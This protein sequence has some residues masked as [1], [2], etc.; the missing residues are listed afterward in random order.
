M[1]VVPSEGTLLIVDDTPENVKVLFKFL[2]DAGFK[3]L[4]AQ[5]GEDGIRKAEHALPDLVLLDVMMP[6]MNGFEVCQVFKSR[7]KL[8]AIPVIF[9]TALT[10]TV[11]KVRGFDVGAADYITKPI[12]QEEVLARVTAHLRLYKLQ[13]QLQYKN[14]ELQERT[15]QL[16]SEIRHRKEVQMSL[17]TANLV[18]AQRTVELQKRTQE[19][20][21]RN[22]ELDAFAHTVAH[23][24]KNPLSGVIGLSEILLEKC[25]PDKPLDV[26]SLDRLQKINDAAMQILGII[27]AILLLAGVS[28]H[29]TVQ[30]DSVDMR[31][32]IQQVINTR[33]STL[34]NQYRA[35]IVLPE[36]LPVARGYTPWI[37]EVWV[38]YLTNGM[39]YG[40]EIP[41]LEVSAE[42]LADNGVKYCIRDNGS[43]ITVEQQNQLFTPFT[44]LHTQRADGH[45]LGL[46]IVK[47][48]VEKLG[49]CV[50][51]ESE[52]GQGSI[53]YFTLPI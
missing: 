13:R 51:V 39:K 49:G 31:S 23:D 21:Q 44:R 37:E 29:K 50:G 10:D 28:R 4:V 34:I 16:Q 19:L 42:I 6:K 30:L 26:K 33:L 3:V 52:L 5:D 46:S 38:N 45:G 48:I 17:E 15:E 35:T 40:G 7:D 8:K 2:T 14:N 27:N 36:T 24:L 53:F 25:T 41:H 22:M 43:G 20:E 12:Q 32:L 18:L 11:D 47:Q 9:M 1:S